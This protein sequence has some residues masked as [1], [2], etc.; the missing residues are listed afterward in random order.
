[1]LLLAASLMGASLCRAEPPHMPP[2]QASFSASKPIPFQFFRGQRIFLSG[3]VDGHATPMMLDSGAVVPV[4][5]AAFARRIGLPVGKDFQVRGATGSVPGKILTG[6]EL[7]AGS[8]HLRNAT[9]LVMDMAPVAT[10]IGHPIPVVLGR[11]AFDAGLVTIDFPHQMISFSERSHFQAPARATRIDLGESPHGQKTLKLAIGAMAPVEADLDLGNGGAL[12][13]A[14]SLWK[15]N[16]ALSS[17]RTA[18]AQIGGV[19]GFKP[20]RVATL[21][22]VTLAGH[23]YSGVPAT[24]NED[25]QSLPTTG[26]NVGIGLLKPFVAT[27]DFSGNTLYLSGPSQVKDLPRERAGLRLEL[28]GDR[29]RVAFVSRDGPAGSAGLAVGDEIVAVDGRKIDADYYDRPDWTHGR[30]GQLVDLEL[31]NRGHVRVKL[32]NYY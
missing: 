19:G 7:S 15:D 25:P 22:T 21:P 30:P 13:V 10:A 29:L 28:A 11:Q 26:A 27:F 14:N 12:V 31:A 23:R 2:P 20:A 18:A 9:V 1:M 6:V 3:D 24:F 4:I 5:D 8:L 17:L 16:A 32:R